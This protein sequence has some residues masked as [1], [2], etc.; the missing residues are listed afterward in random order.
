MA[1]PP[2]RYMFPIPSLSHTI[3]ALPVLGDLDVNREILPNALVNA[4]D[5]SNAQAVAKS[6]HHS[7]RMSSVKGPSSN[8]LIQCA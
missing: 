7:F 1:N 8:V 2:P 4:E 6:L 5:L 3:P